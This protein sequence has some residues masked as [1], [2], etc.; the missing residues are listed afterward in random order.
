MPE[1]PDLEAIRRVLGR[2]IVGGCIETAEVLDPLV[3]RF[4]MEGVVEG[5]LGKRVEGVRRR[6]KFLLLDVEKEHLIFHSMLWGRFQ[7]CPSGERVKKGTCLLLGFENGKELRY[8]D[9]K[10][11]G[12]VYWVSGENYGGVPQFLDLGP[13][14]LG[15]ELGREVF[16]KWIGSYSGMIKN[17]LTNQRFLAGIGNAYADEILFRA[18]IHP[19][20]KRSELSEEEVDGLYESV[21]AVLKEGVERVSTRMGKV[22][23]EEV[24]DFMRV[25]GKGG[26]PCPVCGSRISEVKAGKRLTNFCRQCQV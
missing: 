8:L 25:H 20:R 13:E 12:R 17:V 18:S 6:G 2:E 26:T 19:F 11:M 15:A 7:L 22:L 24:R 5:L 1:L 14:P 10:R 16:C 23:H 9:P 21:R 4:P 3:L